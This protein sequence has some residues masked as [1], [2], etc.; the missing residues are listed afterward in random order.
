MAG[1]NFRRWHVRT[2]MACAVAAAIFG[3]QRLGRADILTGITGRYNF[4]E[5]SGTTTADSGTSGAA[6]NGTLGGSAAFSATHA[7]GA[8][9]LNVGSA[10]GNVSVPHDSE[11]ALNTY[12]VSA[13]ANPT[14]LSGQQTIFSTRGGTDN[15]LDFKF[16]TTSGLTKVHGDI[17]NGAGT[18]LSTS[19]D[20]PNFTVNTGSWYLITYTVGVNGAKIYVNDGTA[21][22][23]GLTQTVS[24]T[25]TPLLEGTS[26]LI[27]IGNQ[28]G[29]EQF[30]GTIDDVRIYN[31]A[32]TASDVQELYATGVPEPTGM[33]LLVAAGAGL[34]GA[35]R[36]RK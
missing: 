19:A 25:G 3:G 21:A 18:W 2:A 33:A 7:V 10:V 26:S 29:S 23:G 6:Q 5:G 31:R 9:S 36:R 8:F 27:T 30:T 12:T 32:L 17:G 24:Y 14:T 1:C 4:E 11:Y 35:R 13:W 34:L 16:I 22:T 15:T 28:N 20:T